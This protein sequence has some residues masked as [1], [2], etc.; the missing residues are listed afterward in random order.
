MKKIK[1]YLIPVLIIVMA[2]ALAVT[3]FL[4]LIYQ[5]RHSREDL[6][7]LSSQHAK[8]VL[9]TIIV[10]IQ[11][12]SGIRERLHNE[13]IATNKVLKVLK[14][15]G[16]GALI[17]KFEKSGSI[18]YIICQDER[19]IIAATKGI[20]DIN[21][22]WSDMFLS[23]AFNK[24]KTMHRI[25]PGKKYH[26]ETVCPFRIDNKKYL[27][28]V[29]FKINSIRTLELHLMRR[30]VLQGFIFIF[31]ILILVLY[32]INIHSNIILEREHDNM[33][34]EVERI[35][36][37][38]RQQER[39]AA[40]GQLAAG[41]AHEIRNPLNAIQI[42][43]QRMER[44]IEPG[45]I[46]KEKFEQFTRIIREEIKRL[47]DIVKQFLDFASSRHPRFEKENPV[48]IAKDI[49]LLE[50][51]V[52][53]QKNININFTEN[54]NPF[55][56]NI[57]GYL[58]K[59]ALVNVIKNAIEAT[60]PLGEIIISIFQDSKNTDFV[61]K[62][63]GGGM[64]KEEREKAFD[65]YFSTKNHG[66]GLGLAITRRIIDQHDGEIIIQSHETQGT[67]VTIRIPNRRKNESIGN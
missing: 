5:Y 18:Y 61:I 4:T 45:E 51:G 9:H 2:I 55:L 57:D 35:Q 28:R 50:S 11:T 65:L 20:K 19:G 63:N 26:F 33:M 60:P 64:T 66:T 21:S 52:A 42:L 17:R 48:D 39:T 41:V 10:G 56:I 12:T 38:L 37:Q 34:A 3:M 14:E 6:I 7:N 53:R 67:I 46:C 31:I 22:I 24:E 16:T 36:Q 25:L 8:I 58:L 43:I 59:Q 30:L 15:Y 62:D 27:L 49:V 23:H 29:C 1:Q 40:M 44:E 32:F 13:K 54:I 47:N